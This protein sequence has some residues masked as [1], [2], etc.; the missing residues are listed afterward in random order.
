MLC[1]ANLISV[2]FAVLL[3]DKKGRH[4]ARTAVK[5]LVGTPCSKV[6][7]PVM[8]S[9]VHVAGRMGAVPANQNALRLGIRGDF[10]DVEILPS[11]K[12][13]GREKN[14]SCTRGMLIDDTKNLLGGQGGEFGVLG[15]DENHGVFWAKIVV[16]DLRLN[17]VLSPRMSVAALPARPRSDTYMITWKCF[18]LDDDLVSL[19]SRLVEARHQQVQ[20]RCQRTHHGNLFRVSS[21]N[22]RHQ[23]RPSLVNVDK[24]WKQLVIMRYKMSRHTLNGPRAQIVVNILANIA[25]LDSKGVP[26]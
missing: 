6:H 13:D 14:Y 16:F 2:Y 20:V 1:S 24:G 11:V 19:L 26:A 9:Q 25:G 21:N 4:T 8:Q 23:L 5:V 10:L 3:V 12:L 18:A 7:V 17:G 22:R 15:L